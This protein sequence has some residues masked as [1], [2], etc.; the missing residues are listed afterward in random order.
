M[1]LL[2][3]LVNLNARNFPLT[4]LS[5]FSIWNLR[6]SC[7]LRSKNEC[8]WSRYL[9]QWSSSRHLSIDLLYNP[10]VACR[11]STHDHRCASIPSWRPALVGQRAHTCR[12][13]SIDTV[14]I[15]IASE[16][17]D[18]LPR[19][20]LSVSAGKRLTDRKNRRAPA[21]RVQIGASRS[22]LS[23]VS[24][25]L[26]N[27]C[28]RANLSFV[29][30]EYRACIA[31]PRPVA[32]GTLLPEGGRNET[33]RCGIILLCSVLDYGL[34][35]PNMAALLF[36][37]R[38]MGSFLSRSLVATYR[39][40]YGLVVVAVGFAVERDRA[41]S[42]CLVV[43][44]SFFSPPL[45][46]FPFVFFLSFF[47]AL[48]ESTGSL[49]RHATVLIITPWY[50]SVCVAPVVDYSNRNFYYTFVIA[51]PRRLFNLNA[52]IVIW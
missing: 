8:L 47:C 46:L 34:P 22:I 14:D 18:G 38:L 39:A 2:S 16:H 3:L 5:Y 24:L 40:L 44:F 20:Y 52:L 10:G 35:A 32:T 13:L 31:R 11:Y 26:Y 17:A 4:L 12:R 1:I 23:N 33:Y 50:V 19:N 41:G 21:P 43:L 28:A 48:F 30:S 6:F 27:T 51:I 15:V 7:N 49:L 45:L 36:N 42:L 25:P 9:E 29:P 37:V